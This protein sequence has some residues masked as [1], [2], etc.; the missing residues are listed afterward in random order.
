MKILLVI[1]LMDM[2]ELYKEQIEKLVERK[3]ET[4]DQY[5]SMNIE[6]LE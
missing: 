6:K 5:K 4:N 3:K 1:S 2:I